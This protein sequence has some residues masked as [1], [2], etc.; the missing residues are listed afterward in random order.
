M[1]QGVIVLVGLA[2]ALGNT[3][4][5][6]TILRALSEAAPGPAGKALTTAVFDAYKTGASRQYFALVVVGFTAVITGTTFMGQIERALNRVYG[7]EEDRPTLQKY[8]RALLLALTAGVLAIAA[9]VFFAVGHAVGQG[10]GSDTA[11][12]VWRAVRWPLAL[13]LTIVSTAL[14]FR[15]S[16]RRRQ[17]AWSWLAL[18]AGVSVLLWS[19]VTVGLGLFFESSTTFGRTYGPLAGM[20]ALLL[21]AFLS[22]VAILFGAAL[23]AQLE[24]VRAGARG[25]RDE[26]KADDAPRSSAAGEHLVSSH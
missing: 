7:I 21:W 5:S 8:G 22:A 10:F 26:H 12:Q 6:A 25:P 11:G 3:D 24:A 16:P 4:V 19:L 14:L 13:T 18:G 23:T 15:W 20:I 17:P 9:L 1:V 2:A